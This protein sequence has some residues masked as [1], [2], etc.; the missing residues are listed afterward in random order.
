MFTNFCVVI[1]TGHCGVSPRLRVG[2]EMPP[3][4]FLFWS[5]TVEGSLLT[6]FCVVTP[7]GQL[8]VWQM[9]A[10]THPTAI[11]AMVPNPNSSAPSSALGTDRKGWVSDLQRSRAFRGLNPSSPLGK[12]TRNTGHAA[13]TGVVRDC[14][15][16][17]AV[18][19]RACLSSG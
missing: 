7:T 2:V 4:G 14:K 17:W 6:S 19:S 8:L 12:D 15:R 16:T 9:R 10:I 13:Y 18:P 3:L 11:I 1:L 5:H